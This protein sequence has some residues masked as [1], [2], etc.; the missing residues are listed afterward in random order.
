MNEKL[1]FPAPRS[2]YQDSV[3][4][5]QN[6]SEKSN[7]PVL[8]FSVCVGPA[9][10]NALGF[11]GIL[12]S[13]PFSKTPFSV[14]LLLACHCLTSILAFSHFSPPF[15]SSKQLLRFIDHHLCFVFNSININSI[16]ICFKKTKLFSIHS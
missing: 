12:G 13:D 7:F 8:P 14:T 5:L 11:L 9:S 10:P 15:S 6:Y 1:Y 4:Q 3:I 16:C 2:A